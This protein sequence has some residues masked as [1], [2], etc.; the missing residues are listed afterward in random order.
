MGAGGAG[1]STRSPA[2]GRSRFRPAGATGP[3][4]PTK[5]DD[6]PGGGEPPAY[7]RW[8]AGLD[9]WWP[10]HRLAFAVV[11]GCITAAD[12]F[13]GE[14]WNTFAPVLAWGMLFG[15]HYLLARSMT[16]DDA[17][18]SRRTEDLRLRAYDQ[19]HIDDIG[20]RHD[21]IIDAHHH[22]WDSNATTIRGSATSRWSRDGTETIGPFDGAISRTTSAGTGTGFG[23]S[24]PSTWKR[25]GIPP[26][27]PARRHGRSRS[28]RRP[29]SPPSSSPR[30][31]LATRRW[32]R[33]WPRRRPSGGCGGCGRSRP[34]PHIRT[35]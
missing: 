3:G 13:F 31:G 1:D 34:R 5:M 19:G 28:R 21:V 29:A 15:L 23:S 25:S 24:A 8:A 14:G 10:R 7:R 17:R 35:K 4:R 30:R 9:A 32:R 12:V 33:C 27:Q 18:A 6:S 20:G 2:P 11:A 22:F 16:M 26:T